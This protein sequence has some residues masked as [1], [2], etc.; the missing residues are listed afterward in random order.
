MYTFPH[1]KDGQSY[2]TQCTVCYQYWIGLILGRAG[3]NCAGNIKRI[4]NT[5]NLRSW[6]Q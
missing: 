3:T 5:F 4:L 2:E 1:L 6:M